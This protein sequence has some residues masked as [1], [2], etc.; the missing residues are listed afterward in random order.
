MAQG[1]HR[2]RNRKR[3]RKKLRERRENTAKDSQLLIVVGGYMSG[4][5]NVFFHICKLEKNEVIIN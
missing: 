5:S 1:E 3:G 4:Q 2:G